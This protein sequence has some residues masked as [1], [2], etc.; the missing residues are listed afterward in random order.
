MV[1][2]GGSCVKPPERLRTRAGGATWGLLPVRSRLFERWAATIKQVKASL[3]LGGI[4]MLGAM[5]PHAARADSPTTRYIKSTTQQDAAAL[6]RARKV[7]ADVQQH[8]GVRFA[9]VQT[10]HFIVFPDWDPREFGFLRSNLEAA[11][12]AVAQ[13]FEI[14][15]RENVFVGKLPV[16][17]F[18][19]L[20][21]FEKYAVE[22]DDVPQTKG[23]RGYYAGRGDGSGHMAMWKPV[24]EGNGI[25]LA[26]AEREWAYTLAH[27]FTHAFIDRYRSN[28]RIPRWMNEGIAEIVAQGLFPTPGRRTQARQLALHH[29]SLEPLFSDEN[30]PGAEWYPAMQGLVQ[31][32]I[33]RDR[34]GFLELFNAIKD[35]ANPQ[36]A[37]KRLYEWDNEALEKAWRDFALRG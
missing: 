3:Y 19:H 35:G 5:L 16:F 27:E 1:Q 6:A 15:A 21:D 23:L 30:I 22:Y 4:L 7:S 11:Y 14:P 9:E 17:M 2:D 12:A 10:A 26:L 25:P 24:A 18:A 13:Q 37:M 36:D 32:L 28:R 29:D 34:R 20:K 8:L 33:A 31:T